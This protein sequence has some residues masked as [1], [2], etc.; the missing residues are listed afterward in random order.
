[1]PAIRTLLPVLG[2]WPRRLAA[3][4]CL[5]L[6]AASAVSARGSE[7]TAHARRTPVVVSSRDL[8]AG[9]TLSAA[10]LQIA[11]WPP[12]LI[13]RG[14]ATNVRSLV[15]HRLSG[16]LA[17]H[18]PVL[19]TRLLGP[20]LTTGLAGDE[21]A[22]PVRVTDPGG[23]A[24]LRPGERIELLAAAPQSSMPQANNATIVARRAL[25]LAVRA[26]R[27]QDNDSTDPGTTSLIVAV[28]RDSA[29]IFA[30][31]NDRAVLAVVGNSP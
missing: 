13:P 20:G 29:G 28:N 31:L 5:L 8:P 24:L 11:R 9:R 17:R 4:A 16:P 22:V 7:P 19:S 26:E 30:T 10:D 15:G 23:A 25:I 21:V 1:M 6:A 3:L 12:E 2:R 18:E 14:A 27:G